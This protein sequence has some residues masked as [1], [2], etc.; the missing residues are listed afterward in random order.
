MVNKS[1]R[2][3]QTPSIVTLNSHRIG[4]PGLNIE[5][6]VLQYQCSNDKKSTIFMPTSLITKSWF[7]T[8]KHAKKETTF[9]Y[10]LYFRLRVP[11]FC[12]GAMLKLRKGN[13][14]SSYKIE[15][16]RTDYITLYGSIRNVPAR[17]SNCTRTW[18]G[19]E[20]NMCRAR[21]SG[22]W[23]GLLASSGA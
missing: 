2:P 23:R 4:Q 15:M 17:E 6:C 16:L 18:Y 7:Y 1:N 22:S 14:R 12:T 19:T 8:S 10:T 5:P 21:P 9:L 13:K 3:I 20:L 11:S